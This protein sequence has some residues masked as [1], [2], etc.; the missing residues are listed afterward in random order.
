MVWLLVLHLRGFDA[1][2]FDLHHDFRVARPVDGFL[3]RL[4]ECFRVEIVAT[5][6]FGLV[7]FDLDAIL[8]SEGIMS[9]AGDLP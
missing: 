9:Y 6:D 4:A 8:I 5:L 3:F 7:F 1:A 2:L